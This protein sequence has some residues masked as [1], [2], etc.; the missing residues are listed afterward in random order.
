MKYF[1]I[2]ILLFCFFRTEAQTLFIDPDNPENKIEIKF[3]EQNKVFVSETCSLIVGEG[4]DGRL[5]VWNEDG[6]IFQADSKN[7]KTKE[8]N[9]PYF[10]EGKIYFYKLGD[11]YGKIEFDCR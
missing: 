1:Y 8:I 10:V 6:T 7:E 9:S 4:Y 5:I 2:F 3:S 11:F